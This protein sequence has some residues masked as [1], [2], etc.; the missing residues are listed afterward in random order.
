MWLILLGVSVALVV[1]ALRQS[2][3][4]DRFMNKREPLEK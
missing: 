4:L 1:E 2:K 3:D